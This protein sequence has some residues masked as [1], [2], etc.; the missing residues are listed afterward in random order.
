[1]QIEDFLD[2]LYGDEEG[3]VYAPIKYHHNKF[4]NGFQKGWYEWPR[5]KENI[6]NQLTGEKELGDC[7]LSPVLYSDT[8]T[9][10]FLAS[11]VVWCDF[12]EGIP[13]E[14]GD[15]PKPSI[16]ISSSNNPGKQHYYWRLSRS[17]R[18][19][20]ALERWN[21]QLAY[22]LGA[23]KGCW[24]F[25]RVLRPFGTLN[26]KYNPPAPV[27]LVSF[28]E[29][30]IEDYVFAALP[31]VPESTF[32]EFDFKVIQKGDLYALQIFWSSQAWLF[33]ISDKT[34]GERHTALTSVAITCAELKYNNDQIM[35]FL[36]DADDRWRKYVGRSDRIQRL[37]AIAGYAR[38]VVSGHSGFGMENEERT[39]KTTQFDN[40][41]QRFDKFVAHHFQVDWIIEGLLHSK[42]LGVV[43]APPGIGKTQFSLN[44]AI[45]VATGNDFLKWEINKPRKVLF[46]SLEMM[47][48]ELKYYLDQMSSELTEEESKLLNDNCYLVARQAFRLNSEANQRQ[49]LQWIDEIQP[50][51]IFIDSLSRCTGGDLEKGEIDQVFDFLNK[52][53]RDKRGCFVWFVHHNRKANFNQKQPKKLEDM[54][55]SQ[56][57]G[58]YAS[59][60]LGLWK[61]N[62]ETIE[63]NSLKIWL[64]KP[65]N[66]FTI[67]R[68]PQLTFKTQKVIEY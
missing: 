68:T 28:S 21:K 45:S 46:L 22:A 11:N 14:L 12:D 31:D 56:Y 29:S 26:H 41:P 20:K 19:S 50:E 23:D 25:S 30:V 53:V 62:N 47:Q 61:I 67:E 59:T 38:S 33:F 2:F 18:D 48:P 13:S 6:I 65:F 43:T 34:D 52:E 42:G 27:S 9:Q 4:A 57:I 58:A 55:G 3:Y 36:L 64:A 39:I 15:F 54:Y 35:S 44:L 51:G 16:Q 40:K 1:M 49:L 66:S 5:H 63:V 24:N 10:A 32:E 8:D 60:V 37:Q 17:T 7:Y